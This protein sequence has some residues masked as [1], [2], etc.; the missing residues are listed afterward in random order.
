MQA[1]WKVVLRRDI[2]VEWIVPKFLS[3]HEPTLDLIC[4][5]AEKD[6]FNIVKDRKEEIFADIDHDVLVYLYTFMTETL[7]Y[8]PKL[9]EL[10]IEDDVH[11]VGPFVT[12]IVYQIMDQIIRESWFPKLRF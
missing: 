7:T 4:A 1:Q 12:Y 6:I 5:R 8:Q 11:N 2:L 9:V 10:S 3:S